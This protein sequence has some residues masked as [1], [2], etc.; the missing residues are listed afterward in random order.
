MKRR[1]RT[2]PKASRRKGLS[3][4]ADLV[5]APAWTVPTR[6]KIDPAEAHEALREAGGRELEELRSE[7][8][9]ILAAVAERTGGPWALRPPWWSDAAA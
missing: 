7:L 2:R 9:Q 4:I 8:L 6:G 3:T 1:R 5:R